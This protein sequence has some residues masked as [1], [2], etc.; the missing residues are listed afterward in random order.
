[1]ATLDDAAEPAD[2]APAARRRPRR[3][4]TRCAGRRAGSGWWP[5]CPTTRP[6]SG[7]SCR[8]RPVRGVR[9]RPAAGPAACAA[10]GS[11]ARSWPRSIFAGLLT[12]RR[13]LL[14]QQH[15]AAGRA[16]PARD[17]HRLLLRRH[18]RDGPARLP[19]T[20]H[21]ATI[22]TVPV[23]RAQRRG[24]RRGPELLRRLVDAHLPA[25]RP[26]G[27]RPGLAPRPTGKARLLVLSWKLEDTYTQGPDPR[28]LPQHRLL[29]TRAR[30]GSRRPPQAY[31]GKSRD[32]PD[33]GPG[34]RAGRADRVTRRRPVRPDGQPGRRP[35]ALRR[36]GPSG[37]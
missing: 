36:R 4:R 10:A 31:F 25:V 22:A 21:R 8:D 20:D 18:H 23:P 16:Q 30:T 7:G 13:G 2:P 28:V 12:V 6:G 27:D 29:R 24:R 14:R 19:A 37:W 33:P 1:M 9:D 35:A 3:C 5:G 15:P 32:E 11:S 26:G 17:H 34:D